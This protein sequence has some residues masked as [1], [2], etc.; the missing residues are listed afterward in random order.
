MAAAMFMNCNSLPVALMQSLVISLPALRRAEDDNEDTMVGRALTYLMLNYTLNTMLRWTIGVQLL[1]QPNDEA[2]AHPL[3]SPHPHLHTILAPVPSTSGSTSHIPTYHLLDVLHTS[4]TQNL[5]RLNAFM[6]PPLWAA[7]V[8]IVIACAHPV[9][10]IIETYFLSVKGALAQA[11]NCSIPLTLMVLGAYFHVPPEERKEERGP[12][13]E[14]QEEGS[15]SGTGPISINASEDRKEGRW[16]ALRR[17][18]GLTQPIALSLDTESSSS[19]VSRP[20]HLDNESHNQDDPERHQYSR[21]REHQPE[22]VQNH[23]QTSKGE[24]MTVC[25]AILSRMVITP[26]LLMPLLVLATKLGWHPI[27]KDPVFMLYSVIIISSPTAFTLAQITQAVSGDVFERLING[28]VSREVVDPSPRIPQ[29][30]KLNYCDCA[31]IDEGKACLLPLA[32]ER[33]PS[34]TSFALTL[35]QI[36]CQVVESLLSAPASRMSEPTTPSVLSLLP[37]VFNLGEL[38]IVP[39]FFVVVTVVSM[40]VA[41]ALSCLAGL[42]KSQRSFTI[43]TAMFMNCNTLPIALMQNLVVTVP[44]LKWRPEDSED[45]MLGRAVTYIMLFFTLSMVVRWS[46]GVQLLSHADDEVTSKPLYP[47]HAPNHL[48]GI[49]DP[50]S[51]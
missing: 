27:F 41:Y 34:P 16:I 23:T 39:I 40:L 2:P 8:S 18:L 4:L 26:V 48:I 43:A 49:S 25:I 14:G 22:R 47:P 7:I 28:D 21:G 32:H 10:H 42:K 12:S 11:G 20:P 19:Y 30:T 50:G 38:W 3:P 51:S 33:M 37:I 29:L 44:V 31:G 13:L 45:S 24:N 9:Q 5:L 17:W 6:T 35:Y 15:S 1:S 36:I 46:F